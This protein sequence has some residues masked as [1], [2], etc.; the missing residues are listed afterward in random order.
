MAI[1]IMTSGGD[2][3]G[4]NPAIK[5]FVDYCYTNEVQPYL[6]YDGLEG[7]IDGA[8]KAATYEDVAGI[9]HEGGTKIRSSRSKRFFEYEYRKQAF[10]NL[11][12]HGIDKIVILGGDGSFRAL[13]QFHK[14]FGVNFV[15]IPATIDN[16]IYGTE[17]CL[18][19]DTA[20][21][22]IRQA[23]DAV[24]DTSASFRRACVIETMGR[25]CGYLA[26]VSAITCGA[27]ICIIPELEYD[28][29][30]IGK[31]LK[32]E[33]A[34]GRKYIVCLVA[35]G[36]NKD[37]CISTPNLVRW[38]EEDI[39]IETRATILGHVQR[40]GNPTV[41]DRLM[42]SEF[43]SYSIDKLL[44]D[45]KEGSVIV[46]KKSEFEFVSIEHVNSQKYKIREDLLEL[47][48]RLVN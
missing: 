35:E 27:E 9:M 48:K 5:Q 28:L 6:I 3:A 8:I 19:V 24:R 11:Q 20:L 44:S 36:C 26:L 47:A 46:Y 17:Y 1:A 29:D 30:S 33:L 16:D 37:K 23:T 32:G 42:A 14:D 41:F 34:N 10:E 15:G 13:N 21:N 38:L 31:R 12:K 45:H 22:I 43:V 39:G 25:D 4:M 40:G 18:G 7:L 2:C